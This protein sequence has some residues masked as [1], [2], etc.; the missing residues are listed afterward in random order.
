MLI[1]RKLYPALPKQILAQIIYTS[2]LYM[3]HSLT[4]DIVQGTDS[5]LWNFQ[6]QL[7][8]QFGFAFR[9]TRSHLA[10]LLSLVFVC[11]VVVID[12]SFDTG[13]YPAV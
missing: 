6:K 12:F 10:S 4:S 9:C 13:S 1:K 11:F 5:E 8:L 3:H 7:L 2:L